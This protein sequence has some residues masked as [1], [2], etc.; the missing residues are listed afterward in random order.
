MLAVLHDLELETYI[1]KVAVAP[2]FSD[3]QNQTKD[4]ETALRWRKGD[5]KAWTWIELSMRD[6]EMVHLIGAETAWEMW[7]LLCMVKESKGRIGILATRQALYQME[8]DENNFDMVKHV[9]RLRQLQEELHLMD[10]K[11]NNED[12]IMILITSLPESWNT[13]TS[14]YLGSSGNKP[15]LQSHKLIAILSEEDC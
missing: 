12:F 14:A 2:G 5:A 11:V 3:P 13:Y 15:T 10:N 4:E 7:D 1:A 6:S 8:A 9:S